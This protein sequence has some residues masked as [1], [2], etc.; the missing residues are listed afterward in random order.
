MISK[1]QSEGEKLANRE[2]TIETLIDGE[3]DFTSR[4]QNAIQK[5]YLKDYDIE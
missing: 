2:I 5:I 3:I 1:E 4:S